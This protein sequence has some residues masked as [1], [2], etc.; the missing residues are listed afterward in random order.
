VGGGTE[1]MTIKTGNV[2]QFSGNKQEKK[3]LLST[4][5][6]DKTTIIHI[7]K[8]EMRDVNDRSHAAAATALF[9]TCDDDQYR[10]PSNSNHYQ[11]QASAPI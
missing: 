8:T 10:N 11:Q 5:T 4:T 9:S 7:L 2:S 1:Y 6:Y 3:Q